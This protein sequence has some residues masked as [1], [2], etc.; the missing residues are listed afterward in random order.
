MWI[1]LGTNF[2]YKTPETIRRS[3][4]KELGRCLDERLTLSD[5]ESQT[6][7]YS[8]EKGTEDR[9][10]EKLGKDN[11]GKSVLFNVNDTAILQDL[12]N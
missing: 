7:A 12:V 11:G 4:L 10:L 3:L 5:K 1:W 6:E 2:P 9:D 8:S